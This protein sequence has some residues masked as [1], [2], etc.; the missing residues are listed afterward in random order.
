MEA[1]ELWERWRS[2]YP[3]NYVAIAHALWFCALEESIKPHGAH[4]RLRYYSIA[5]EFT[6]HHS[7]WGVR[8]ATIN[9]PC[10][11]CNGSGVEPMHRSKKCTKCKGRQHR[12]TFS[13]YTHHMMIGAKPLTLQTEQVPGVIRTDIAPPTPYFEPD[14]PAI[15][16]YSGMIK[17]LSYV[18][19]VK[20]GMRFSNYRYHPNRVGR[21]RYKR[22]WNK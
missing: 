15:L 7:D 6:F 10:K 12:A 4:D 2:L 14:V 8:S 19:T 20:M 3:N 22:L 21:E 13:L 5:S 17:M 1:R 18:A 9:L 11:H 16:P